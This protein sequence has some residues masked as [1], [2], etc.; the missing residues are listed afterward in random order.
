VPQF[1]L[2]ELAFGKFQKSFCGHSAGGHSIDVIKVN[3]LS[4]IPV[5][6]FK[7]PYNI[8]EGKFHFFGGS[9]LYRDHNLL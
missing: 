6:I 7:Y 5:N 4:V 8:I 9:V 3:L 1:V 2:D